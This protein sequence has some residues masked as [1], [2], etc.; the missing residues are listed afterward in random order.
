M[1]VFG[2]VAQRPGCAHGLQ[3]PCLGPLLS[4]AVQMQKG[5][6]RLAVGK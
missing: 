5:R 6:L 3:L 2:D 1:G 4:R